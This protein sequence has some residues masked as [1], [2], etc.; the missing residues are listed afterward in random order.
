MTELG[1]MARDMRALSGVLVGGSVD[2]SPDG[3][4]VGEVLWAT[5]RGLVLA[6]MLTRR[7][8]DTSAERAVLVDLIAAHLDG[9]GPAFTHGGGRPG[10]R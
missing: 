1:A 2:D 9:S 8:L 5:L 4:V 7:P 10:A 6:Q 3:A